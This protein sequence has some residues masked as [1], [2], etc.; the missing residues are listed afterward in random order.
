MYGVFIVRSNKNQNLLHLPV[1]PWTLSHE[2]APL[3]NSNN[4]L[5]KIN[6]QGVM[7]NDWEESLALLWRMGR[8]GRG[9][10]SLPYSSISPWFNE[11]G[12]NIWQRT[13][14]MIL[15]FYQMYFKFVKISFI[16]T[17]NEVFEPSF[18]KSHVMFVMETCVYIWGFGE[19]VYCFLRKWQEVQILWNNICWPHSL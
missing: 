7:F 18:L 9:L 10:S 19:N 17:V 4:F 13:S 14:W 11:T 8:C 5:Y 15:L 1:R 6:H 12:T 16:V 3:D 2:L